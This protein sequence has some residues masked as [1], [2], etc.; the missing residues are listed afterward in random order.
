[1]VLMGLATWHFLWDGI[2][3]PTWRLKLRYEVF[4]VRDRLRHIHATEGLPDELFERLHGATNAAIR[5]ISSLTPSLILSA[6]ALMR[7]DPELQEEIH[8]REE[9]VSRQAD[10]RLIQITADTNRVLV[11]AALVNA[12]GWLVWVVPIAVCFVI[13][14]RGTN[15]V[16]RL[17]MLNEDEI[18]RSIPGAFE[19]PAIA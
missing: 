16:R 12:G 17:V 14:K 18:Q 10:E 11:T 5:L 6:D 19:E 1:M 3:S 13:L 7:N 4:E 9:L 8:R 15:L 2:I